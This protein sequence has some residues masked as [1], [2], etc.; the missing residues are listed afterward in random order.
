MHF[1]F[2]L[3]SRSAGVTSA[4]CR[5]SS[6]LKDFFHA[7]HDKLVALV[8]R[9]LSLHRQFACT[10]L[11]KEKVHREIES[12]DRAIEIMVYALYGLTEEEIKLVERS[13]LPPSKVVALE[14]CAWKLSVW[15]IDG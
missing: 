4:V 5:L 10:P 7:V 14:Q 3:C 8:D 13:K 15:R 2:S 6:N 1:S 11:E 12:T 9:M